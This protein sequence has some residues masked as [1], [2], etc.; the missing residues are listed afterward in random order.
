VNRRDEHPLD[1]YV[2]RA[3][4]VRDEDVADAWSGS[5]AEQALI[6]DI[7]M[8]P[9]D[10]TSSTDHR[11]AHAPARR[12]TAAAI[13]AGVAAA[14]ALVVTSPFGTPPPAIA[15]WAPEPAATPDPDLVATAPETCDF[16][17]DALRE[18]DP[19]MSA[20]M[21]PQIA[22]D[23]RGNSGVVVFA[24][25]TE[26][27]VCHLIETDN[28]WQHVGGSGGR[29]DAYGFP[30]DPAFNPTTDVIV[31]EAQHT[32]AVSGTAVTTVFGRTRDDVSTV[33]LNRRDGMTL[34]AETSDGTFVAW[35]PSQHGV[36]TA[37]AIDSQ[38]NELAT[39]T[40]RAGQTGVITP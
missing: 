18:S 8:T 37:T 20:D 13:L 34:E 14:A 12:F 35:W 26:Y 2:R 27:V 7:T 36:R 28:G 30:D 25:D 32:W 33:E 31:V 29:Y 39:V 3:T 4:H 10:T 15:G 24:S 9:S 1:D 5:D 19:E 21:P 38:G 40:P 23:Q 22:V 11:T 6:Q 17:H 16:L